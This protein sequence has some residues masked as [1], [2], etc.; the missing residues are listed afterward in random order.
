MAFKLQKALEMGLTT[1]GHRVLG[2]WGLR[3]QV[4]ELE[5]SGLPGPP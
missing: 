5:S 3:S 4:Y 1:L 2:A